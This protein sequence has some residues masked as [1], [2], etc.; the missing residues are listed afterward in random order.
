MA[1][2]FYKK[3]NSKGFTLLELLVSVFI[4]TMMSGL[5]LVNYESTNSRTQL[6][7]AAQQLASDIRLTQEYSLG[8]KEYKGAI[9]PGGWGIR[10]QSDAANNTYYTIF[11]DVDEDMA[12]DAVEEYQKINLPN[13]ITIG[14]INTGTPTDVIFL[15]PDPEVYFNSLVSPPT[16]SQIQLSD[17]N[18]TKT[19]LI[20]YLGLVDVN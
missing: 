20:N 5:F 13:G 7:N 6:I 9:S 8:S 2:A 11:S 3:T 16:N 14:S 12:Y 18:T 1:L 4:I 15:P 17:G 10:F 19:V